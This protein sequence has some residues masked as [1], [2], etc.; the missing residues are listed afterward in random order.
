MLS[1]AE[2]DLVCRVGPGTPMGTLMRQY[3]IPGMLS[4]E[5]PSPDCAPVRVLL[6]GEPL[7]AWRDSDGRV[8]MMQNS[9]PHR[10]ASLFYGRNEEGGLRCIYHGWKFDVEGNCLDMLS[11]PDESNFAG[12]VKAIAYPCVERNGAVW[13]YMGPEKTPPPLPDIEANI[14][15]EYHTLAIEH[16]HNW[17][18]VLEGTID[19]IHAGILHSGATR[20]QDMPEGSFQQAYLKNR[21]AKF[22]VIDIDAGCTYGAHRPASE[23]TEY[24]RIATFLFPFYGIS[25]TGGSWQKDCPTTLTAAVPMDDDHTLYVHFISTKAL[26]GYELHPNTTDWYGRFNSPAHSGNDY[27]LDRELQRNSR[28]NEGGTTYSGIPGGRNQ[29]R[30]ITSSMGHI[31]DRTHEHLGVTDAGI[32]RTRRR[33]LNAAKALVERGTIPP[34]V[35]NPEHYRVRTGEIFLPE[36]ANWVEETKDL[37]K[38]PILENMA[39]AVR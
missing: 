25:P 30:A 31:Y 24:W 11:E 26:G 13:T 17:L 15:E 34:G 20:W 35:R 4:S 12:K 33:L 37:R 3:W 10:G 29:D 1:A 8:G 22:E 9:C 5:L 6:L 14:N 16:D 7:I 18:Q 27:L 23:G 36:G 19:T 39:I 2:N 32:I 28:M 21:K 38:A